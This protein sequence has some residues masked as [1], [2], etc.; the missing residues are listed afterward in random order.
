MVEY[1]GLIPIQPVDWGKV[2]QDAA[3]PI[4]DVIKDRD[5]QRKDL[6]KISSDAISSFQKYEQNKAPN[7]AQFIMNASQQGRSYIMAQYELLTSGQI[8]P[9]EFKRNTQNTRES[10]SMLNTYMKTYE[11]DIQKAQERIDSGEAGKMERY[12]TDYRSQV[13]D[14]AGKVT[15]FSNN[16]SMYITGQDGKIYDLQSLNMGINKQPMKVDVIS[17]VDR[18]VKGLGVGARMEGGKYVVSQKLMGNWEKTKKNIENA[19]M[20]NPNKIA[21]ILADNSDE[22]YGFTFDPKEAGGLNILIETDPNGIMVSKPTPEQKAAAA[23]VLKTAIEGRVSEET[24]TPD[25]TRAE[26]LRFKNRELDFKFAQLSDDQRKEQEPLFLR[27]DTLDQITNGNLSPIIGKE[28]SY[29]GSRA[30]NTEDV[31]KIRKQYAGYVVHKLEKD[32]KGGYVVTVKTTNKDGKL[33]L[34]KF[35]YSKEGLFEDA[36]RVLNSIEGNAKISGEQIGAL[37]RREKPTKKSPAQTKT[38][39]PAP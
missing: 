32:G 5:Q 20:D 30:A 19:I 27:L 7:G 10:F 11:T 15:N 26:E 17:E 16:G 39:N 1:A 14:L 35:S 2:A 31:E 12:L 24:K 3:K 37:Q 6:E 21:S 28:L 18:A 9:E 36:N 22:E 25:N 8:P 29:S 33:D 23:K 13:M 34:K 38:A 4:T